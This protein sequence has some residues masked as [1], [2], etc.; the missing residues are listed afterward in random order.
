MARKTTKEPG[1][2]KR[3]VA[4]K[5]EF[6][7]NKKTIEEVFKN[8]TPGMFMVATEAEDGVT[9]TIFTHKFSHRATKQIIRSLIEEVSPEIKIMA[10]IMKRER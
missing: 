3:S 6:E 9:V 1:V 10:E 4:D 5:K 8:K 7:R 2:E